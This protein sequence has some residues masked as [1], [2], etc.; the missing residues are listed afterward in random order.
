MWGVCRAWFAE[1]TLNG[2]ACQQLLQARRAVYSLPNAQQGMSM[3]SCRE[4]LVFASPSACLQE[5]NLV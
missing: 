3:R 5:A 1:C 2:R 4:D